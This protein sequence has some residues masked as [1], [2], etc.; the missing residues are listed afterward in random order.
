MVDL[1]IDLPKSFLDE[2]EISGYLVT[3]QMKEVWAV[4][5]DLMAQLDRVCRENGLTFFAGAGT[6]LGAVRH[7]GFIPWD[8]DMDFYML[9]EDYNKLVSL[10][11]EFKEP[12]FLQN[13]YTEP[14]TA[15]AFSRLRNSRTMAG[16]F[17][18]LTLDMN[19]GIFI[20]IFP[21]DGVNEGY[22]QNSI[23]RIKNY[24][25]LSCI[26]NITFDF[27]GFSKKK[28]LKRL[29]ANI[30][31]GVLSKKDRVK[32][33]QKYEDNLS[34]YSTKDSAMWGN[35]TIVFDCPKSRRPLEDW[36]SIEMVPFEFTE[37]PVPT[38][39]HEIL[40]QQYGDYMKFPSDKKSGKMHQ[41]LIIS[42]DNAYKNIGRKAQ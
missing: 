21:L 37:I 10:A 13:T 40:K 30:F 11:N 14:I 34:K 9:R 16:S 3:S 22:F 41:D 24:Y 28:A 6:L 38:N 39:Y 2:E 19:N 31:I 17:K 8:D 32:Y 42:T 15:M 25:Y 1:Q 36:L 29:F 26:R 4:E 7:H 5:L 20:D 23:Q 18:S 12:Y 33:F 35:R 27:R